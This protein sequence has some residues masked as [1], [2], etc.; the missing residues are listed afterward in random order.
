[1]KH[2]TPQYYPDPYNNGQAVVARIR[3]ELSE[4]GM[5]DA[6]PDA[7]TPAYVNPLWR[8]AKRRLFYSNR[9]D[10]ERAKAV[11]QELEAQK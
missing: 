8:A 4:K 5:A 10:Y 2:A 7:F 9:A 11:L 3:L 6:A 1:M